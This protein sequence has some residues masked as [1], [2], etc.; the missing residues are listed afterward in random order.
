MPDYSGHEVPLVPGTLRGYRSWITDM[1]GVLYPINAWPNSA[2]TAGINESVCHGNC[3][4]PAR[5]HCGS[6]PGTTCT[7]GFY[8]THI[9]LP[10][11]GSVVGVIEASGRVII[12]TKGFRAQ[13]ARIVAAYT[14]KLDSRM[15]DNYRDVQWFQDPERMWEKYPP[16]DLSEI[17]DLKAM[18]EEESRKRIEA[19]NEAIRAQYHQSM[20]YEAMLRQMKEF[21]KQATIGKLVGNE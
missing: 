4:I 1:E 17:V 18:Q 7:C 11:C 19:W 20:T 9:P 10:R 13:K 8:A 5:G 12:G 2:W 21:E 3:G 14:V 16:Q 6:S 15:L